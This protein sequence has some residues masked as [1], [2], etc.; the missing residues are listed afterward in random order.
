MARIG[1]ARVSSSEQDLTIQNERLLNAGCEI[2]RLEKQ[3]GTSMTKREELKTILSFLRS[4]DIL[5]VTKIDRLARSVIDLQNIVADIKSKNAFLEI[6]DQPINTSTASGK[7]FL[8]M[9]GVFAE[10]ENNI[11]RERQ[12]EGIQKAKLKGVYKG[13]RKSI[14][15]IRVQELLKEGAGATKISEILGI[16]RASVYRLKEIIL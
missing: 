10:F 1:Y 9:L 15:P 16:S 12:M 5:V 14:D 11:R 6:I 7:A 3:S 8:D 2:I 13:R 4:D